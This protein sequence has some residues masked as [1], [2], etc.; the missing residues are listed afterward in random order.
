MT[1]RTTTKL[2]IEDFIKKATPAEINAQFQLIYNS[3]GTNVNNMATLEADCKNVNSPSCAS[4]QI[5]KNQLQTE[6]ITMRSSLK[7]LLE[8]RHINQEY[9]ERLINPRISLG[10]NKRKTSKGRRKQNKSRRNRKSRR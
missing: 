10:G 3:L 7:K 5:K 6:N 1:A 9:N 8:T 4:S 2:A